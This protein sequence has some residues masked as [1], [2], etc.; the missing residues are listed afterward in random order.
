MRGLVCPEPSQDNQIS[1]YST[2]GR[3]IQ[4]PDIR[5][6]CR[7]P[8]SNPARGLSCYD[9]YRDNLRTT[10]LRIE[11]TMATETNTAEMTALGIDA[12]TPLLGEIVTWKPAGKCSH[13]DLTAALR[14]SGLDQSVAR[15]LLPRHAFARAT[16]KLSDQRIIRKLDETPESI[17]FQFTAES[18]RDGEFCYSLETVLTLDKTSG[19]VQCDIESLESLAQG[20]VDNALGERTAADISKCVKASFEKNDRDIFAIR[21]EGGAYFVPQRHSEFTAMIQVFLGRLNGTMRRFPIPAGTSEGNRSV[22]ESVESGLEA[23]AADIDAAVDG[24]G[25]DT[26][27]STMRRAAD[28]IRE[29]WYKAESY[30][31]YLGDAMSKIADRLAQSKQHLRDKIARLADA[32]SATP[33]LPMEPSPAPEPTVEPV[34]PEDAS[35]STPGTPAGWDVIEPTEPAPAPSQ[36]LMLLGG[37]SRNGQALM[38]S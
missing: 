19:R 13:S 12:S 33:T 16:R 34:V 15:E 6:A 28:H 29:V 31:E 18:K 37:G 17:R 38:F 3:R 2:S 20:L 9:G 7:N 26:R 11:N 22:R 24:F 30:S 27:D 8:G 4:P 35:E 32:E 1:V 5:R 25:K 14:D 21:D 23:M 10:T 36:S